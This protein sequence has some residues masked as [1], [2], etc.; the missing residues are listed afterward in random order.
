MEPKNRQGRIM[1]NF[2]Y[3]LL[4]FISILSSETF[5]NNVVVYQQPNV[6]VQPYQV[7]VTQA[8]YYVVSVPVPVYTQTVVE[9][10]LIWA[11]PYYINPVVYQ[12]IP[13]PVY[14]EQPKRCRLLGY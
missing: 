13:Q 6:Y 5:A 7:M 8:P 11:Y 12:Y 9:Q 2:I 14:Y 1:K 3:S 10:R 4:F